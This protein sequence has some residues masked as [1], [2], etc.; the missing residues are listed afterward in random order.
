MTL[1]EFT[2]DNMKTYIA[3]EKNQSDVMKGTQVDAFTAARILAIALMKDQSEVLA[4][5][6]KG[7]KQ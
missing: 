4:D 1:Y 6:I 7:N 2:L 3:S 5:L